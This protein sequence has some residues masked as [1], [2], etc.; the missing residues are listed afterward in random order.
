MQRGNILIHKSTVFPIPLSTTNK[1]SL[2]LVSYWFVVLIYFK[3]RD[4]FRV[5]LEYAFYL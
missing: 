3:K 4:L 5:E 1:G 2:E